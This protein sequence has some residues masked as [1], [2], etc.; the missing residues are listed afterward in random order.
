MLG[1]TVDSSLQGA[2][3]RDCRHG[4]S[5]EIPLDR[6]PMLLLGADAPDVAER[7]LESL[8]RTI[9]AEI[10]PRLM[11]AHRSIGDT[12][13]LPG[14]FACTV[15]STQVA[16]FSRLVLTADVS[17]AM[18]AINALRASGVSA[19]SLCLD[20]L[21]PAARRLGELWEEDLC[22]FIEVTVGLGRLQQVLHELAPYLGDR[23]RARLAGHRILLTPAPGEQHSL[24][25]L[26]VREF[27]RSAGWEV[28]GDSSLSEREAC[29]LV[30]AEW[31]DL[32]GISVGSDAQLDGLRSFVAS[33]RAAS[34]NTGI[35]ILVGG[36]I[37]VAQPGLAERVGADATA[38]DAP[39]AVVLAE[40][41]VALRQ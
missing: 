35:G 8:V 31:F 37:F 15:T 7:Q 24:G 6:N 33:I 4:S 21:A 13:P 18:S 14:P 32:V 17:F 2:G 3:E 9:E 34:R 12:V 41:L 39:Q 19:Q 11:L 26:I 16:D 5:R 38:S 36:P 25:L 27:F 40:N 22:D 1:L 29:G 30:R 20:L 28:F 10:I 23:S